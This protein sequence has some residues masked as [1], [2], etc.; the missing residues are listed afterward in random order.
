MIRENRDQCILISGES[1]AGKTES[2][3][4]ILEYIGATTIH[5]ESID[6][7]K[8]KLLKSNSI[9]EAFGNA[10]TTRNNN[11][12]RF[13]KYMDVRFDY[14]GTPNGGC[15][16]NYLLEKSR[17]ISHSRN[18]RNFHIFYQTINGADQSFLDGIY[19]AKDVFKYN[20][21]VRMNDLESEREVQEALVQED[22]NNFQEIEQAFNIC[23]F[24]V[25][26][27]QVRF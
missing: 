3:K 17:V 22:K 8:E 25:E 20:Y 23:D 27:R 13:G 7:I 24:S 18:E 10:K 9:L 1:G 15:I 26:D 6:K 11:S 12:S 14:K 16:L 4:Y 2:S 5:L 21:L 19:L